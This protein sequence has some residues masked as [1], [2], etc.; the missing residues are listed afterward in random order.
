MKINNLKPLIGQ[1]KI[2]VTNKSKSVILRGFTQLESIEIDGK[3]YDLYMFTECSDNNK[4]NG[5]A[6]VINQSELYNIEDDDLIKPKIEDVWHNYLL[7]VAHRDY[8]KTPMLF[9]EQARQA[10]VKVISNTTDNVYKLFIEKLEEIVNGDY[11][12]IYMCVGAKMNSDKDNA[13]TSGKV[14]IE[15]GV[16]GDANI[17]GKTFN[18]VNILIDLYNDGQDYEYTNTT[19]PGQ[20]TYIYHT[21]KF[22]MLMPSILNN[23]D[24]G[25]IAKQSLNYFIEKIESLMDLF[26]A[27]GKFIIINNAALF[28]NSPSNFDGKL[29]FPEFMEMCIGLH[30]KYTTIYDDG[31]YGNTQILIMNTIFFDIQKSYSK[32]YYI[33]QLNGKY[34]IHN[35]DGVLVDDDIEPIIYAGEKDDPDRTDGC[36]NCVLRADISNYT[37]TIVRK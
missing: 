29:L 24:D 19:S 7:P 6:N 10:C 16:N 35:N 2:F 26:L 1:S 15:H 33:R 37:L 9:A 20:N 27:K 8:S 14:L 36:D 12:A 3:E 34:S 32:N 23:A 5:F 30:I 4:I 22:N 28:V 18:V 21:H 13:Y 11:D 31:N 17:N 25:S